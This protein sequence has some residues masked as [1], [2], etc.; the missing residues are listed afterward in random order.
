MRRRSARIA[1]TIRPWSP[2]A[3]RGEYDVR[4]VAQ[5]AQRGG[6]CGLAALAS[7]VA[8]VA[9][10]PPLAIYPLAFVCLVPLLLVAAR[11]GATA[12]V[13]TAWLSGVLI[14]GFGL[15]WL[16]PTLEHMQ[17]LGHLEAAGCLVAFAAVHALRWSAAAAGAGWLL[18]A[19][20]G[21]L[22]RSLLA[23]AAAAGWWVSIEWSIPLAF[24]WAL[25]SVLGPARWLRQS[26]DIGGAY[27]LSFAIVLV[28]GLLALA[29]RGRHERLGAAPRLGAA[30]AVV[31]LLAGYGVIRADAATSERTLQVALVQ[32]GTAADGDGDLAEAN[33]NAWAVYANHTRALGVDVV[34]L[35]IWPESVLRVYLRQ[36][37]AVRQRA[38]ALVREV[39]APLMLGALDQTT[40]GARELNSAYL[41]T[42]DGAPAPP[43]ALQTYHKVA[44]VP[45][46]EYLPGDR[47]WTGRDVRWRTTGEFVAGAAPRGLRLGSMA[48]TKRRPPGS[49]P[50]EARLAPSICVEAILPG[51]F[52][53]L[54]RDGAHVLVNLTDDGWFGD[55]NAPTQHLEMTRLRAVET[56]RWLVRASGSGI[57]AVIDPSGE[58]VASLPYGAP[59]ALVQA[60]GLS[61]TL[62][63]YVRYGDWMVVASAVLT[64][65]GF[66]ARIRPRSAC[67]LPHRSG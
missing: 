33:A 67:P 17:A 4:V 52:N 12:A 57:S 45:F 49:P 9:S 24:P 23:A 30:L 14:Y 64:A 65:A 20:R 15:R 18:G 48:A 39:G 38:A 55:T 60:V 1:W 35:V 59:G 54:V 61:D 53:P 37:P 19:G 63:P 44:L 16:A 50:L 56:R 40:D 58:I 6:L 2:Y 3:R 47:F 13:A 41:L 43:S 62:T 34:D 28:N 66:V 42:G 36:S 8:V 26:A 25:G 11:C 51:W 22:S 7:G 27:G 32:G 5:R 31:G 21:T 10:A 29:V 46:A